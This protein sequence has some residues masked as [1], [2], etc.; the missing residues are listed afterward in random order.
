[1][2]RVRLTESD[3]NRIVRRVINEQKDNNEDISSCFEDNGLKRPE[4]CYPLP[5]SD[6][7]V[8]LEKCIAELGKMV[9]SAGVFKVMNTISCIKEK[10]GGMESY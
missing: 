6:R 3:L 1:M 9:T 7:G 4:Y 2:R 8:D 10:T 5:G